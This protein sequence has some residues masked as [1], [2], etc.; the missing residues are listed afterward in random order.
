MATSMIKGI[1]TEVPAVSDFITLE[2]GWT[3]GAQEVVSVGNIMMMRFIAKYSGTWNSGIQILIGTLKPAY[4]PHI[5]CP[6]GSVATTGIIGPDGKAY[7]RNVTGA[8]LTNSDTTYTAI[9]IK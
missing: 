1:K 2:S 5:A 4:R 3:C 7:A 8:S 6:L 9:F